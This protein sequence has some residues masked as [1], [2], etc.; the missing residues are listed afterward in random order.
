MKKIKIFS[1]LAAAML[2]VAS[3]SCNEVDTFEGMTVN[4][5]LGK[6]TAQ[7]SGSSVSTLSFMWDAVEGAV[8]YGYVLYDTKEKVI[9]EGTTTET[10]AQFGKLQPATTYVLKVYAFGAS[11]GDKG[12]SPAYVLEATTAAVDQL[13]SPQGFQAASAEGVTTV[14]WDAV[15]NAYKYEYTLTQGEDVVTGK[16]SKTSVAFE[17]LKHLEYTIEVK[18]LSKDEAYKD[19]YDGAFKFEVTAT[20]LWTVTGEQTVKIIDDLFEL[21]LTAYDD[22]QY[23]LESWFGVSGYD[24]VFKLDENNVIIPWGA[25]EENNGTYTVPTGESLCP[26]VYL[27]TSGNGVSIF[28]GTYGN[29]GALLFNITGYAGNNDPVFTW[30]AQVKA[31]YSVNGTGHC[32]ITGEDYE[33]T[34]TVYNDGTAKI[35]HWYGV[36]DYDIEFS[37]NASTGYI[38]GILN[39]LG[40]G[41]NANYE[42]IYTGLDV[43]DSTTKNYYMYV[44]W[45]YSGTPGYSTFDG[46]DG[47]G[48][49]YFTTY[50][51]GWGE[52]T[53]TWGS[54]Y[55]SFDS[56]ITNYDYATSLYDWTTTWE[57]WTWYEWDGTWEWDRGEG[58]NEVLLYDFF[59]E[60]YP[61]IGVYNRAEGTITIQPTEAGYYTFAGTESDTTPVVGH[62]SEDGSTVTFD[63]YQYW[64]NGDI[65]TWGAETV[66]TR[67]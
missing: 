35:A 34:L 49:I 61:I 53:F 28:D 27:A 44:Y 20:E 2:A 48:E 14:S 47:E 29:G 6:P 17:G 51:G 57:S 16:T 64:Y 30:K 63:D 50:R 7:E 26:E 55:P 3:T 8:E 1:M 24:L 23:K 37:Y 11:T 18:A 56:L 46:D 22:G 39:G 25:Y 59:Y 15:D 10:A 65:Y 60:Y 58:F 5:E 43:L 38:T 4:G 36:E 19:S 33:A 32:S 21:T 31:L 52:Y 66:F 9:S 41:D 40:W 54:K 13:A 62:V 42:G 45:S 67:K 12:T